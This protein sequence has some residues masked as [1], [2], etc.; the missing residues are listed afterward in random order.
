MTP[1]SPVED[2]T[3]FRRTLGAF[4]T[5]VTVVTARRPDGAPVGITANSFASVSLSPPL[6]LWCPAKASRR[7]AAFAGA[8]RF[9]VHVLAEGQQ[10]ACDA[11]VRAEGGFDA[12]PWEDEGGLPVLGGCL[13]V[14]LCERHAVL[15]AGDH[16][17]I[18]GR[19]AEAR[20]RDGA[21]LVFQG[22]RYGAFLPR[23]RDGHPEPEGKA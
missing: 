4:A 9:A 3:A 15:E 12:V 21:P 16:A 20:R 1:F 2:A 10:A 22:G 5:G 17:V 23:P 19:V 18:L 13:A 7:Y 14:L 6:V 8:G 11:F